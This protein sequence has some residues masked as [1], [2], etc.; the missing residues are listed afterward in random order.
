MH[1]AALPGCLCKRLAGSLDQ[2]EAGIGND[3]P[4]SRE[5]S[6]LELFV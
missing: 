3:Q 4:Y 1:Y 5:A 6:L 2:A